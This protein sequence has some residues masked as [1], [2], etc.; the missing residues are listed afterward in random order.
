MKHVCI[1]I[2]IDRFRFRLIDMLMGKKHAHRARPR[3][4]PEK[5]GCKNISTKQINT[6]KHLQ[7]FI[8]YRWR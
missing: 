1:Q 4:K 7:E 2:S 3:K 8:F 5:N 6:Q